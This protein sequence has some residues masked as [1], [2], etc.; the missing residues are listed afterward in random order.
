[1]TY[2]AKAM[3]CSLLVASGMIF[4]FASSMYFISWGSGGGRKA[5]KHFTNNYNLV[6][7]LTGETAI[8]THNI[9]DTAVSHNPQLMNW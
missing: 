7:E 8:I 4:S 1:M 2:L 3:T 6:N 5:Y 9:I